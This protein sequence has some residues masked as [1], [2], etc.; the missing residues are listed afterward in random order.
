MKYLSIIDLGIFME[1][2]LEIIV[3]EKIPKLDESLINANRWMC[4]DMDFDL[5]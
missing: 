1:L 3:E 4:F 5:R 2:Y